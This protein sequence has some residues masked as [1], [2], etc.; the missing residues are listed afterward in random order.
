MD[1][2]GNDRIEGEWA[3][4]TDQGK[5]E[6]LDRDT[7]VTKV[8]VHDPSENGSVTFGLHPR[9]IAA[10]GSN[11]VSIFDFRTP[12]KASIDWNV[13]GVSSLL[14]VDW[15][16]IAAASMEGV[17]LID[18]RFAS[19]SSSLFEYR[20]SATPLSLV[21]HQMDEFTTLIVSCPTTSEV[22]FF[23]FNK[24]EYVPPLRPFDAKLKDYITLEAEFL[25]GFAIRNENAIL[26]FEG[27]TVASI[28]LK[29]N[30]EPCRFFFPS[31]RREEREVSRDY[32]R[33]EPEFGDLRGVSEHKVAWESA[34]PEISEVPP[35]GFLKEAPEIGEMEEPPENE[36]L[37]EAQ[38]ALDMENVAEIEEALGLFWKNHLEIARR[39]MME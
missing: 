8:S 17:S 20:F 31:L 9:I 35:S 38:G 10:S 24:F 1:I 27:G 18:L 14:A 11:G 3:I 4:L 36:F 30:S 39:M 5:L 37:I 13:S 7:S 19:T 6:L 33:F 28:E 16:L 12:R 23:S 26:Q 25:T 34:F 29:R 32:F 2:A 22:V 21:K 15:N